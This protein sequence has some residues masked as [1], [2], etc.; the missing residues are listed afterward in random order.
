VDPR[1][2]PIWT[3]NVCY[4]DNVHGRCCRGGS[5]MSASLNRKRVL[6]W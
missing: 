1:C 4:V 3:R 6:C 2:Q 5:L